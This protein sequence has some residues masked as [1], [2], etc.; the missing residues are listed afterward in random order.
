[1]PNKIKLF[2]RQPAVTSVRHQVLTYLEAHNQRAVHL[3]EL[4]SAIGRS[5]SNIS[6]WLSSRAPYGGM[7]LQLA[8]VIRREGP[9]TYRYADNCEISLNTRTAGE[10]QL[11]R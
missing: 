11:E 8:G 7:P 6:A 9:G 2:G 3:D 5:R 4:A 10:T 1:M